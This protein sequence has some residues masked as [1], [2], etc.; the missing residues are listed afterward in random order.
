MY[1]VCMCMYVCMYVCKITA[2]ALP[3]TKQPQSMQL[4]STIRLQFRLLLWTILLL[5]ALLGRC[6]AEV[7]CEERP[8]Y[9][10]CV[11]SRI[12]E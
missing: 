9:I 7:D 1:Y 6:C 12:M 4:R 8:S 3:S 5:P 2:H 10:N 11:Y